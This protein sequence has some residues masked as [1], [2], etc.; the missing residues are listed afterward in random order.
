M[1]S[2][3]PWPPAHVGRIG[4]ADRSATV[5]SPSSLSLSL[6]VPA[7]SDSKVPFNLSRL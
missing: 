6:R 4:R 2:A 1:R 7:D 3:C 5:L